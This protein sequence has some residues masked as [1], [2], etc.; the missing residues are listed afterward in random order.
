MSARTFPPFLLEPF[1]SPMDGITPPAADNR[2]IS[3]ASIG[4]GWETR[5]VS[6]TKEMQ[7]R[8][9]T[10]LVGKRKCGC[11]HVCTRENFRK[12]GS[13]YLRCHWVLG[14]FPGFV[15]HRRRHRAV[16]NTAHSVLPCQCG[17]RFAYHKPA[18][19][20]VMFPQHRAKLLGA[21]S[22]RHTRSGMWQ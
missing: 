15:N 21:P 6:C 10:K 17:T 8:N 2:N 7:K 11:V 19:T 13:G 9:N 3:C 22:M 20:T 14:W 18:F 16:A 1:A 4:R 5:R 12:D